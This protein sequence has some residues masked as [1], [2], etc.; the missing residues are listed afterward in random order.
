[1]HCL[2][3]LSPILLVTIGCREHPPRDRVQLPEATFAG[4]NKCSA[5]H[6][7]QAA[8]MEATPHWM[9][10]D[11]RSPISTQGCETCHGPGSVHIANQKAEKKGQLDMISFRSD[12]P[13]PSY[14]K[15]EQCLQCHRRDH[16]RFESTRHHLSDVGCSSCHQVHGKNKKQLVRD[17]ELDTC[18]QCHRAQAVAMERVSHHPVREGHMSCGT[19]HDPHGSG[20]DA[21]LRAASINDLCFKCHAEKRG[22]RLFE[23]PPVAENC[24]NCHDPHGT[25]HPKMLKSTVTYLCQQCHSNSGHPG[26]LYSG[27]DTLQGSSP[28]NRLFADGCINCHSQVHGSNHPSGKTLMR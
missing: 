12:S 22:P 7:E 28:S 4:A 13:I 19:C 25:I 16:G 2:L 18:A 14:Q 5:C 11:P 1:M 24:M 20:H 23:H 9:S 21:N 10:Q 17:S 8:T 15:D 26:T 27:R 6:E 3:R